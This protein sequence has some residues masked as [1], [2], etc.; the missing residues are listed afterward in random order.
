MSAHAAVWLQFMASVDMRNN[1]EDVGWDTQAER[2]IHA[3]LI[4]CTVIKAD[5]PSS[6]NHGP[7]V[8]VTALNAHRRHPLLL[9]TETRTQVPASSASTIE[10]TSGTWRSPSTLASCGRRKGSY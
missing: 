2:G 6:L 9:Q 3:L 5:S 8:V 10:S 7:S 1:M 4:C